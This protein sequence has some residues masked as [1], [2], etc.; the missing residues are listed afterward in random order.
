MARQLQHQDS[1]S[2][3]KL[4]DGALAGSFDRML[5]LTATPFQLGH[6]ELVRVLQRFS[7]IGTMVQ[8]F[9]GTTNSRSY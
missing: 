3:L 4:G 6:H 2:D 5:F 8:G 7:L 9:H 1:E